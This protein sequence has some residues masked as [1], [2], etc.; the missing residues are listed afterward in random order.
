MNKTLI[1]TLKVC[2]ITWIS[3]I[4][5]MMIIGWTIIGFLL[6][7]KLNFNFNF[8]L[9]TV[10]LNIFI[11]ILAASLVLSNYLKANFGYRRFI[12]DRPAA[13]AII[14]FLAYLIFTDYIYFMSFLELAVSFGPMFLI[15]YISRKYFA[16]ERC[17]IGF[18][19]SVRDVYLKAPNVHK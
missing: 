6:L 9:T 5:S 17:K 1:Y 12:N 13:H 4:P 16:L 15:A 7:T 14:A 10:N 11:T 3:A 19:D 8:S 2:G 18:L